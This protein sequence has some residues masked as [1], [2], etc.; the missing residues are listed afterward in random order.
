M[1]NDHLVTIEERRVLSICQKENMNV[2]QKRNQFSYCYAAF[3]IPDIR[4]RLIGQPH[5]H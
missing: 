5:P 4:F 2:C 3:L 1:I